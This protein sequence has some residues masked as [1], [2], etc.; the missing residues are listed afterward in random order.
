M[1]IFFV[2]KSYFDRDTRSVK[3]SDARTLRVHNYL[4]NQSMTKRTK[5][6][7]LRSVW[8]APP[9][10]LPPPP[11]WSVIAPVFAVCF[12]GSQR[13]RQTAKTLIRLD[14]CPNWS[15]SLLG[16][17]II[18][19]VHAHL[20]FPNVF[21]IWRCD[22]AVV[23]DWW[24]PAYFLLKWWVYLS[25]ISVLNVVG[26]VHRPVIIQWISGISMAYTD[27]CGHLPYLFQNPISNFYLSL[28]AGKSS[29]DS[30]ILRKLTNVE[31]G[32]NR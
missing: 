21:S 7:M 18:F 16:A 5:W 23:W 2:E 13:S 30:G 10:P 4:K 19:S 14:L 28:E 29:T 1:A 11:V 12:M 17:H 9:P 24:V 8:A 25:P 31:I 6:P 15:E 32:Q 26:L 22:S 20:H 3:K 27:F